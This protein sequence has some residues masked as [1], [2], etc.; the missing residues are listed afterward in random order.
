MERPILQNSDHIG[1][2]HRWLSLDPA[3]LLWGSERALLDF[4]GEVPDSK[5]ACCCPTGLLACEMQDRGITCFPLFEANLHLRSSWAKALALL[6][7]LRALLQFRPTVLHVNQAGVTRIA[8]LACRLLGIACVT[9]VRLLEDVDYLNRLQP[10]KK[11]LRHL[12]AIS[13]PIAARIRSQPS[14]RD[15]PC[16]MMLDAYRP[17]WKSGTGQMDQIHEAKWEFVCVGRIEEAK[18]QE[19]LIRALHLLHQRGA[20]PRAVFVGEVNAHAMRLIKLTQELKLTSYI[21]F[22]GYSNQVYDILTSSKWLVCPSRY[23]ALGRVLFE[24][25]D[26]RIPVIAGEFSGGAASS[27]RASGGGLLFSEWS[28]ESLAVSMELALHY[29]GTAAIDLAIKGRDWLLQA[30]DPIAYGKEMKVLLE[31]AVS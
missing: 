10:D 2:T 3:G 19:I 9:H 11:H 18:G 27:V 25:W 5:V 30:T 13:E 6:G 31:K 4:I 12:I 17:R 20:H 29:E 16:S 28:P 7:L 15:I 14:L 23:E 21:D 22:C 8:L 24:A 1:K 26:T